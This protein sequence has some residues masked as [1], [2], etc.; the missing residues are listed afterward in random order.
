MTRTHIGLDHKPFW[1]AGALNVFRFGENCTRM[2]LH[3][4]AAVE[5][6]KQQV[7]AIVHR[8][9]GQEGG[10]L[11]SIYYHPCEWVDKEF[12]DAVNFRR[13]ANPPREQWKVPPQW[14]SAETEAAFHRFAE[15]VDYIRA[16]PG[17]R[18]V[19]A[20]DLPLLYPDAVRRQGTSL[21]D[22]NELVCASSGARL[23]VWVFT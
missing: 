8:M 10:G 12:W 15:Y 3:D 2:D 14:P 23:P 22:I 4:P 6:A 7:S 20:S 9:K 11:I 19:T 18:F 17:L 16:I 5:P 13:G 1:Y 21:R